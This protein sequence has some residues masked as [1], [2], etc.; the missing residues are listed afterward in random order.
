LQKLIFN[1][2]IYNKNMENKNFNFCLKVPDEISFS[3]PQNIEFFKNFCFC[4]K[5][6]DEISFSIP[7]NIELFKITI[8]NN[9]K[10]K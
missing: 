8:L 2:Y 6:P 7:Q 1:I 4:L 3:V 5:V 9:N 10:K